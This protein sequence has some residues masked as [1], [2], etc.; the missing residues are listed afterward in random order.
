MT[1]LDQLSDHMDLIEHEDEESF[2][3]LES[4]SNGCVIFILFI[5]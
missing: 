4:S 3:F 2:K 5:V 1:L